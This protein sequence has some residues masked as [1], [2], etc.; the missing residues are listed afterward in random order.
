VKRLTFVMPVH[1]RTEL[2]GI[3]LRQLRRTCDALEARDTDPIEATAIVVG[4]DENLDTAHEL[5]FG[6]VNRNNDYLAQ[7]FNDGIELACDRNLNPRPADFAVPFGS[8]DWIDHTIIRRLPGPDEVLCFRHV[9]FVHE[10]GNELTETRLAYDGGVGI[11]IYPRQLLKLTGYRPAEEDR[12][13]G[14]DTSILWNTRQEH[15]SAGHGHLRIR[16]GDRHP[17]QIVDWKT[18]GHQMNAY[19]TVAAKHHGS[20]AGDPFELL[21]AHYPEAALREMR[22]HYGR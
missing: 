22:H 10:N 18:H 7:K 16:Y 21:E 14:C 5:G 8:D 6:T 15:N 20:I 12:R 2:T 4:N 1:G 3:C 11:R 19:D 13:R 9:A 17:L